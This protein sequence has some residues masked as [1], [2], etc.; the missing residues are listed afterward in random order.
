ML[1]EKCPYSKEEMAALIKDFL[2]GHPEVVG[3]RGLAELCGVSRESM[4]LYSKGEMVP[5]PNGWAK[6]KLSLGLDDG[7]EP[8]TKSKGL[9]LTL[10]SHGDT[11]SSIPSNEINNDTR[12]ILHSGS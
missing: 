8:R 10:E 2:V 4:R 3:S 9:T 1:I 7:L 5:N 6:I 12:A 11:R